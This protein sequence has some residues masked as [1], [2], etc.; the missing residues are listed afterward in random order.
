MVLSID[1][2]HDVRFKKTNIDLFTMTSTSIDIAKQHDYAAICRLLTALFEQE[3]DFSPDV[4]KQQRAVETIVSHPDKGHI[5]LLKREGSVIGMV[6]LLYL[7]STA[8]G[9][10]VALL[11]DLIIT[12][13]WRHQGYGDILLEAAESFA[14]HQ[15]CLR[16]TLLTDQDNQTAQSLYQKHGFQYSAMTVMR[17]PLED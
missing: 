9:G 7:P 14:K 17:K 4:E 6:S 2:C 12:T 16:I 10:K 1:L 13:P 15:G 8:M 11:E 3:A 5:L